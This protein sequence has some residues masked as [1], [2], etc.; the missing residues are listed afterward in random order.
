MRRILLALALGLGLMVAVGSAPA[1]SEPAWPV[2]SKGSRGAHAMAV[3]HLLTARGFATD[4]DGRFGRDTKAK[5]KAFQRK[6]KLDDDGIVGKD[7]W[8]K[9][10]KTVEAGDKNRYVRA[11]QVLLNKYGYGLKVDGDFGARTKAALAAFQKKKGIKGEKNRVGSR[12]WQYL[13][14]SPAREM[15]PAVRNCDNVTTGVSIEHTTVVTAGHGTTRV[16]KC[17]AA[18]LTRLYADAK[19]DGH[20]LG[21]WGFRTYDQ[22]VALRKKH[23]GTSKWEIYQKAS[24]QCRPPTARPGRSNHERGTAID[25]NSAG[26]SL[27]RSAFN[28]L[29]ANA[30]NY[31]LKNLPSEAWHWSTTG[32]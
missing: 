10:V 8:S 28:W 30:R 21:G 24:S 9:L 19:R 29:A 20:V 14:G 12:S 1:Q 25:F 7:T 15:N 6:K 23:C 11:A 32:N 3:Q 27:S 17:L 2:L 5:T 18:D 26:N 13:A 22:Q 31:G 4:V 16:H